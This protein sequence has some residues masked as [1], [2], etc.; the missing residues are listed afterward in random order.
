MPPHDAEMVAGLATYVVEVQVSWG[1]WRRAT[2]VPVG[3]CDPDDEDDVERVENMLEPF[4]RAVDALLLAAFGVD[5]RFPP[6]AYRHGLARME[7]TFHRLWDQE[8]RAGYPPL[9]YSRLDALSTLEVS[10]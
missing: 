1:C 5:E 9:G 3:L 4:Y 10:V 7:L 8:M 2:Y 6:S